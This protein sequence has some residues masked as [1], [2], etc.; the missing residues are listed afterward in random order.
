[1]IV[2]GHNSNEEEFGNR[3]E[4][5]CTQVKK[6]EKRVVLFRWL[7]TGICVLFMTYSVV[8]M[9]ISEIQGREEDDMF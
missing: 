8:S 5:I 2:I 1:M 6:L 7:I 4:Q 3:E 9:V